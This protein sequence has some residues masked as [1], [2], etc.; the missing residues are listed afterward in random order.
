MLAKKIKSPSKLTSPFHEPKGTTIHAII[1]EENETTGAILNMTL[2][3]SL[4]IVFFLNNRLTS[5]T[6]CI[7]P[8][9]FLPEVILF[10]RSIIPVKKMIVLIQP[11]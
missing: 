1:T 10:V 8:G 9:P 11:E 6:G 2:V 4:Y 5:F 3:V 7:I